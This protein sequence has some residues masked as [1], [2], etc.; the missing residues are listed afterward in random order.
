VTAFLFRWSLILK[1][2]DALLEIVGGVLL[3]MPVTVNRTIQF[4]LDHELVAQARHHTTAHLEHAAALALLHA[5]TLGA[6]YLIVHGA[7]KVAL[8]VAIFRE[9]KWGYIGLFAVLSLFGVLELGRGI[10]TGHLFDYAFAAFDLFIVYLIAKEYR[11]HFLPR[12]EDRAKSL[13]SEAS[14]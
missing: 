11:I 7:A 5:T 12:Q 4:L 9:K 6:F 13:E 3:L 14:C 8:I 10:V 1:G 2:L